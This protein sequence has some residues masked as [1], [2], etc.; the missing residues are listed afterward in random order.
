[1]LRFSSR[2][3]WALGFTTA[4]AADWLPY[5]PAMLRFSTR[6]VSALR[7]TSVPVARVGA[8]VSGPLVVLET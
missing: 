6:C 2:I 4:A 8:V 3:V 5:W 1:M 7:L